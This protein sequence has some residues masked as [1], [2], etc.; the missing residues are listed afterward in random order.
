MLIV[1][2]AISHSIAYFAQSLGLW[3]IFSDWPRVPVTL[4]EVGLGQGGVAQ[5]WLF[6]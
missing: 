5:D 2:R 4:G 1:Y 3:D 6:F